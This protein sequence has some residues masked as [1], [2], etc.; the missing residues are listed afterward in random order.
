MRVHESLGSVALVSLLSIPAGC[1][2]SATEPAGFPVEPFMTLNGNSG[3]LHVELRTSPQPP[4]LGT[5][6]AEL[7]ITNVADGKPRDGL[8]LQV[9]PWMPA[10]NHGTSV[11]PT[12]TAQ[13]NGKYLVTELNLFMPGLWAL[14]TTFSGPLHDDAAP[15]FSVR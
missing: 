2:G 13:R 3:A 4:A 5:N 7:T 15:S 11:V 10:M 12:V 1:S 14:R 9:V 6:E 8:T